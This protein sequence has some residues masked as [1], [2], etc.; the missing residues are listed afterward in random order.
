M[1]GV[2]GHWQCIHNAAMIDRG[3]RWVR[4]GCVLRCPHAPVKLRGL[5]TYVVWDS[6]CGSLPNFVLYPAG[7][8][9]VGAAILIID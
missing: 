4:F 2:V 7:V 1:T 6:M 3:I 5:R 9:V 8:V